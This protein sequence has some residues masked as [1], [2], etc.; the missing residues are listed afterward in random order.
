MTHIHN[1]FVVEF[2]DGT[3]DWVDPVENVREDD[4]M[5]YVEQ[6]SFRGYVY[7][8]EK[9]NVAKWIIRPYDKETTYDW[10]GENK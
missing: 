6:G 5:L 4:H 1:E 8:Y 9:V 10:I 3:R 2:K 7:E